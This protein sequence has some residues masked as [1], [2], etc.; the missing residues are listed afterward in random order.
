MVPP[1][2]LL[3]RPHDSARAFVATLDRAV[4][5]RVVIAP[6][7][8]IVAT[9]APVA[10]GD[11][12]GV[13]FTSANGVIHGPA[14]HR[15]MAYCVGEQTT[16]AAS[17]RGWDARQAGP[18]AQGLIASLCAN[19]PAHPLLHLGGVHTRGEI[20]ATLTQA[21][22]AT[23]HIAVYDQILVPLDAQAIGALNDR[24]IVPVFSPRS[25]AQLVQQAKGRLSRAHIIA[26]S[27]SVAAPFVTER[28]ASLTVL[29]APQAG[30][31][32]KE[33]ENLCLHLSLP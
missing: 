21:G 26:L 11:V 9:H 6:L 32:R 30:Y 18:D 31:M 14:G 8:K 2:L 5:V 27:P 25:A 33:V 24:C 12:K 3:T 16:R 13:I 20:A 15:Q 17:R 10:M 19:P 1:T 7:M 29:A 22:I 4:Q 28:T 23:D